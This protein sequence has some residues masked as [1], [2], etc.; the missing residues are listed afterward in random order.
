MQ[1]VDFIHKIWAPRPLITCGGYTRETGIKTAEE[2]GQIIAYGIPFITNVSVWASV[3]Q[4]DVEYLLI[5][6]PHSPICLSASEKTSLSTQ[7]IKARYMVAAPK[8]T[9][10][11]PSLKNSFERTRSSRL[12]RTAQDANDDVMKSRTRSALRSRAPAHR[13]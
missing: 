2:T 11:I 3:V 10:P 7:L 4:G 12:D 8:D 13:R 6:V 5:P 9:L 1:T